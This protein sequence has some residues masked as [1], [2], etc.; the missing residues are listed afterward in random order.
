M[1]KVGPLTIDNIQN[2]TKLY[3][4]ESLKCF[5]YDPNTDI[6]CTAINNTIRLYCSD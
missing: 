5:D 4:T 3:E 1:E 2:S 6:V